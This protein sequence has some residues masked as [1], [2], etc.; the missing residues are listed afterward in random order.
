MI[1]LLNAFT[2]AD[3]IRDFTELYFVT[4]FIPYSLGQLIAQRE[5]V[6][7]CEGGGEKL[8]F[9]MYQLLCGI[10]HLHKAGIVHRDLSPSNI[11]VNEKMCLKIIDLGFARHV[12]DDPNWQ[13]SQYVQMR[14]YR[15]PEVIAEMNYDRKGK[16]FRFKLRI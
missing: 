13:M 16:T 6:F 14:Y 10:R 8:S 1:R 9:L 7:N 4:E 5:K 2:P 15:A 3:S 12:P 11:L